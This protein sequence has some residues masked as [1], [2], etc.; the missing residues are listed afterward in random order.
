MVPVHRA[1]LLH[2]LNS[3]LMLGINL[4]L[5]ADLPPDVVE[6][7]RRVA[8]HLSQLKEKDQERSRTHLISQRRKVMLKVSSD[9]KG[10]DSR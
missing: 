5:L 4:S 10:I 3:I 7:G 1:K 8:A 2:M 9:G 6:E